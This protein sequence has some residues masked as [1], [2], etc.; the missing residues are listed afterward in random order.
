MNTYIEKAKA[1]LMEDTTAAEELSEFAFAC[2]EGPRSDGARELLMQELE[3]ACRDLPFD[4]RNAISCVCFSL[5]AE[6]E[7]AAFL[8]GFRKGT[9]LILHLLQET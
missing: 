4:R 6:Y 8:S 1:L 7:H 3:Q 5:C 2:C 9:G